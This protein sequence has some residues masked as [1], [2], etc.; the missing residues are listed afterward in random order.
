MEP[1]KILK[2]A[3]SAPDRRGLE[4]HREAVL[5]LREK[6]YSW[7]DIAEFLTE[8]GVQ[9]DHTKVYRM[10]NKPKK[11][12]TTMITIPPAT[13]YK[14]ALSQ[15]KK[16][17]TDNQRAMLIAHFEA[18]SRSITYTQLAAAMGSEKHTDANLQYGNLGAA[19]GEALQ[20]GFEFA[21]SDDRPGEKFYSSSIGMKNAYAEGHFQLVMHHELAKAIAELGCSE[22]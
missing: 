1:S 9:T 10:F 3:K 19:L 4:V 11:R 7:R 6:D 12:K 15:I 16:E 2:E 13:E 14:L 22:I 21:D 18:P 20:K 5:V 17:I 8:R